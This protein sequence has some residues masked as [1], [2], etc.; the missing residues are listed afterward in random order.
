MSDKCN[1]CRSENIE[2][3]LYIKTDYDLVLLD[4][5]IENGCLW[6]KTNNVGLF[7]HYCPVCGRKLV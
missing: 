6:E 7:I 5:Y 3:L 2:K 4:V 1:Y